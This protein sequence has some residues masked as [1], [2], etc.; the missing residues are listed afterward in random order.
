MDIIVQPAI[1]DKNDTNNIGTVQSQGVIDPCAIRRAATV[2]GISCIEDVFKTTSMAIFRRLF[3]Q[4][5]RCFMAFIP[6]GVA[7][8]PSPKRFAV[9]FMQI[10]SKALLCVDNDGNNRLIGFLRNNAILFVNPDFSATCITPPHNA[11]APARLA[12][13]F[14]ALPEA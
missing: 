9:I 4:L 14:N 8:L 2:M 7:A 6:S 3:S 10:V 13:V 5:L 11:I 12:T 1:T